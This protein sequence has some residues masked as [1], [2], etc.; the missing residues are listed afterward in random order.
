MKIFEVK[1]NWF[2]VLAIIV[3]AV[4]WYNY[5]LRSKKAENSF[6]VNTSGK[7]TKKTSAQVA[8]N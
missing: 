1:L 6:A 4:I 3:L 8:L 5:W 7:V 2:I